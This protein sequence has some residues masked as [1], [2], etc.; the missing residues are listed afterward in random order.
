MKYIIT[1]LIILIMC[2]CQTAKKETPFVIQTSKEIISIHTSKESN[3]YG[4]E[5]RWVDY[6]LDENNEVIQ[7]SRDILAAPIV[8]GKPN[9]WLQVNVGE[10]YKG[11]DSTISYLIDGEMVNIPAY[12]GVHLTS[13]TTPLNETNV[14]V[15]GIFVSSM[16]DENRELIHIS[17]PID[18]VCTLGEEQVLYEK[19]TKFEQIK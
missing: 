7:E 2:G 11:L 18:A 4:V 9:Q 14:C 15:K 8:T 1:S 5:V 16:F 12:A 10:K 3:A 19:E 6:R 13:K 17:L